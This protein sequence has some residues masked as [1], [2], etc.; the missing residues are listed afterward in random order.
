MMKYFFLFMMI[1]VM[2]CGDKVSDANSQTAA[3][4][5]STT[6]T[7]TNTTASVTDQPSTP[8]STSPTTQETQALP[9]TNHSSTPAQVVPGQKSALTGTYWILLELN[10]KNI[11]GKTAKEMYFTIDPSSPQFK[12][13]SGCNLVMGEVKTSGTNK[14]WFINLLPTSGPCNTPEIDVEFQKALEEV[15]EYVV[16]GNNLVLSKKGSVPVMKF[17]ARR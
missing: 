13:H 2:S 10:G 6:Q 8:E 12:S 4:T 17:V 14:M 3:G 5:T 11:Q 1:S 9:V 16:N 15:R 7:T